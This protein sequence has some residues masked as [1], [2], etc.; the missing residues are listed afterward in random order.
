VSVEIEATPGFPRPRAASK[1]RRFDKSL[2][3]RKGIWDSRELVEVG[4]CVFC[5]SRDYDEVVIR[6]DGLPIQECRVCGLA[7]VDPRPSPQ[8]L[9]EYYGRGYFSGEKD[10]FHGKDYCLERDMAIESGLVTGYR[11]IVSNFDLEGKTILDLGC[12]SGAL[13][14]SLRN[15]NPKELIG[16]DTAE[17]PVSF[18]RER[19]DLDLRCATLDE[20]NLPSGHFDLVALIDMIEHVEDLNG[21][22]LQLQRVVAPGGSVIIITPN[23]MAYSLARRHWSCLFKDFEHLHYFCERSLRE[24]CARSSFDLTKCWTDS[25]PFRTFDYPHLYDYGFHRLIHPL[26][27]ARNV[28]ASVRYSRALVTQPLIGASLNAILQAT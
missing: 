8:Q 19:Y 13:L 25:L 14:S 18:G 5:S 12:A 6:K 15:H 1:P 2:V 9:K 4:Q 17:Y 10:F 22:L 16:I 11:E 28:I 20:A 23:Y 24:A 21:F 26:V 7:F 27:A 3:D